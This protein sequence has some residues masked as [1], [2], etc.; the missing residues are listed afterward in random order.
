MGNETIVG[1]V[2]LLALVG[3]VFYLVWS[4]KR[5]KLADAWQLPSVTR[6]LRIVKAQPRHAT[7]IANQTI[8]YEQGLPPRNSLGEAMNIGLERAFRKGECAGYPVNR[9]WF[10]STGVVLKSEM[11]DS[12]HPSF[13]V[14]IWPGNPYWNSDWDKMKGQGGAV[15]YVLAAG[16]M[17]AGGSP[18]GFIFIAPYVDDSFLDYFST[19]CEYE[20]E[21]NVYFLWDGIKFEE[22]KHHL[23]G[24]H[25]IIPDTCFTPV[26]PVDVQLRDVSAVSSEPFGS[27][28]CT[29]ITK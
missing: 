9:E 22:T 4:E 26:A 23:I 2:S 12:G 1:I 3:F 17:V 28:Y 10:P 15:H 18:D 7:P 20:N 11:S 13:R 5:Q 19:L 29:L 21:H 25:P 8:I 24:G 14:P 6:A 16:Q 27:K